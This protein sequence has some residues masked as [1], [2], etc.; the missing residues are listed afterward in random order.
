MPN[1]VIR[2]NMINNNTAIEVTNNYCSAY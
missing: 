2:Q 1:T